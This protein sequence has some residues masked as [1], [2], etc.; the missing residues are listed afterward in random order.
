MRILCDNKNVIL[1]ISEA[2][3]FG[4]FEG[5]SKWKINDNLYAIDNNYTCYADLTIPDEVIP[6]KYCYSNEIGFYLN[7]NWVEPPKPTEEILSE[8]Q[9]ENA[10]LKEKLDLIMAKL[11]ITL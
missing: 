11:N 6:Y 9:N 2:L 5:E 3:I 8:L 7:P 1:F 10:I 4:R